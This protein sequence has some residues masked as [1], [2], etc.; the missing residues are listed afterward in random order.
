MFDYGVRAIPSFWL[1][2]P[3]RKIAMSQY[4]FALAFRTQNDLAQIITDRIEGKD[5]PTPGQAPTPAAPAK[6]Q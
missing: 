6:D 3:E 1:I 4:D 5:V 2:S